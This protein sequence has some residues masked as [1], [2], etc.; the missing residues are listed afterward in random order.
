MEYSRSSLGSI[1][2]VM[3]MSRK[4]GIIQGIVTS[5]EQWSCVVVMVTWH[6][7]DMH[8]LQRT[9][10]EITCEPEAGQQYEPYWI[11]RILFT[12]CGDM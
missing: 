5:H 2:I 1:R 12:S 11:I 6:A 10:T 3:P 7:P 9:N 4:L 8:G